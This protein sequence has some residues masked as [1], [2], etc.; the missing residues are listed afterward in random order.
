[1]EGIETSY[2][3]LRVEEIQFEIVAAA[4]RSMTSQ[5]I[6]VTNCGNIITQDGTEKTLD[7][8]IKRL[9]VINLTVH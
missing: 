6:G 7:Y 3:Y 4:A 9:K 8:T 5:V 2:F 1:M